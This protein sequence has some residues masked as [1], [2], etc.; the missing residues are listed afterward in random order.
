MCV[1]VDVCNL[2]V[3][4]VFVWMYA[5]VR[6]CVYCANVLDCSDYLLTKS[7]LNYVKSGK[8][9]KKFIKNVIKKK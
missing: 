9:G 5:R 1:C 2:C 4:C 8:S 7:T 6:A 3:L